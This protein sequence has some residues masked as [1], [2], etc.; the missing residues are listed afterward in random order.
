MET[1][2]AAEIDYY[3]RSPK[4][5][6]SLQSNL[7]PFLANTQGNRASTGARMITQALPL[8]NPDEP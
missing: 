7:I 6:F 5:M 8:T 4:T 3:L 1:V 2:P